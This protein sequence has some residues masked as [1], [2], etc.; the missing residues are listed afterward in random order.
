MQISVQIKGEGLLDH[1]TILSTISL[2]FTL[3]FAYR[4]F[5]YTFSTDLSWK[6]K[7]AGM[8]FSEQFANYSTI[9]VFS[10]ILQHVYRSR[11][12]NNL[13]HWIL[14]SSNYTVDI[15]NY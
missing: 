10:A 11:L 1:T 2:F 3:G 6:I 8:K 13:L 14:K 9:T 4:K 7:F 5:G 12:F 15:R